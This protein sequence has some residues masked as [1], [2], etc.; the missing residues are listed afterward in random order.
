MYNE[1]RLSQ[2]TEIFESLPGTSMTLIPIDF[3]FRVIGWPATGFIFLAAVSTESTNL[4]K[5][6]IH[7]S[8]PMGYVTGRVGQCIGY[9][10]AAEWYP[11]AIGIRSYDRV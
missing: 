10:L 2:V 4:K 8:D 3:F 9:L 7:S 1:T 11:T 6:F 5:N